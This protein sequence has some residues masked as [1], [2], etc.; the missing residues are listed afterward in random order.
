MYNITGAFKEKILLL[1]I[2]VAASA[3]LL[4]PL[5]GDTADAA[6]E[7]YFDTGGNMVNFPAGV[8]ELNGTETVLT[9][10]WYYVKENLTMVG[11]LRIQGSVNLIIADDKILK[12]PVYNGYHAINA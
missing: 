9:N 8:I 10:G 11:G 7:Q 4:M 12:C 5:S 6:G 1:A 3:I 2:V